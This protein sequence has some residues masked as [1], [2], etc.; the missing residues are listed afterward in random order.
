MSNFSSENILRLWAQTEGYTLSDPLR[1]TLLKERET[2]EAF[3]DYERLKLYIRDLG[4]LKLR[5][6]GLIG[7]LFSYGMA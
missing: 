1:G 6:I 3:G 2:R 4:G 7:H 5:S